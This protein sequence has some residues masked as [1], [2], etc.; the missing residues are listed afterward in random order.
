MSITGGSEAAVIK[1][2]SGV[3]RHEGALHPQRRLQNRLPLRPRPRWLCA[4]RAPG[5]PEELEH[6]KNEAPLFT[7]NWQAAAQRP[8]RTILLPLIRRTRSEQRH[9]NCTQ[10]IGTNPEDIDYI[11]VHGTSTPWGDIAEVKAIQQVLQ[12]SCLSAEYQP[13]KSMTGHCWVLQV[14]LKHRRH[15]EYSSWFCAPTINHFY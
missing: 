3:Q 6:A 5:A 15:P 1:A 9:E 11:N 13:T 4:G 12:R 10:R 8:M 7:Q 14:P 2:G